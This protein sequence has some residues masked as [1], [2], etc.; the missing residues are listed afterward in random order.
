MGRRRSSSSHLTSISRLCVHTQL[1]PRLR[2][3]LARRRPPSRPPPARSP[4]LARHHRRHRRHPRAVAFAGANR[5]CPQ[6]PHLGRVLSNNF[7]CPPA[8]ARSCRRSSASASGRAAIVRGEERRRDRW[9]P[10]RLRRRL[11]PL[12]PI[13][14]PP[15][16]SLGRNGDLCD[17]KLKQ[18]LDGE[19]VRGNRGPPRLRPVL[20]ADGRRRRLRR[21]GGD[22]KDL[23]SSS[24]GEH[25]P[26]QPVTNPPPRAY[27]PPTLP[28]AGVDARGGDRHAHHVAVDVSPR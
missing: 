18:Y 10:A 20:P 8:C 1:E 21:Q 4:L 16:S 15:L 17:G 27:I 5:C 28:R 13:T 23:S 25:P 12:Q 24:R 11:L 7:R 3:P 26:V 22:Q 9:S 19:R 2:P 6:H 14:P